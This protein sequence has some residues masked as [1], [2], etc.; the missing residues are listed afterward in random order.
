MAPRDPLLLYASRSGGA[1]T[2]HHGGRK[3][4]LSIRPPSSSQLAQGGIP[5]LLRFRGR[6]SKLVAVA[7]VVTFATVALFVVRRAAT[8]NP[9]LLKEHGTFGKDYMGREEGGEAAERDDQTRR[10]RKKLRLDDDDDTGRPTRG[11][12]RLD[13]DRVEGGLSRLCLLFPW[14]KEC[15]R[16][17]ELSRDPFA[18]FA[19]VESRGRLFYPAQER[20]PD[21]SVQENKQ[22]KKTKARQPHPVHLVVKRAR[23]Q[24]DAKLKRQ[25]KTLPQAIDE[26][27]RRYQRRPPR[28]FD[29]WYYHALANDFVLRDEFDIVDRFVTPFLALSPR[30]VRTRHEQLQHDESFWLQVNLN[31]PISRQLAER[32]SISSID[33]SLSPRAGQDVH[34]RVEGSGY[35]QSDPRAYELD[36][37]TP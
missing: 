16:E 3:R 10:T 15:A 9:A 5:S 22:D 31:H 23:E 11:G 25:S 14:R 27:E 7:I 37:P 18:K 12:E 28:G 6:R 30:E 4:R 19:Y 33:P 24:W 35:Q 1:S 2:S 21:A 34:D 8:T 20:A 17:L 29:E 13:P 32:K 26:Y 36:K